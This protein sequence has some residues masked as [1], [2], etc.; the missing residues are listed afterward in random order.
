MKNILPNKQK[1]WIAVY[2]KARHEKIVKEE[3]IKKGFETYLPLLRERRKWS[4][5][6]KWV[7]FPMFR[8]YVFVRIYLNEI[9]P[10]LETS[11][12]V[13]IISFGLKPAVINDKHITNIKLILNGGYKPQN[14]D[15]FTRGDKVIVNQGPLKGIHGEIV[16]MDN[17]DRLILRINEIK[18][19]ISVKI[20][21]QFLK[22]LV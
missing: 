21:K 6:K 20:E 19:A 18:N 8:S 15:Y 12:V 7:E 11:G 1:S 13:R 10:V 3:F 2:T 22:I 16:R 9:L 14:T 5:R 17:H 4:D